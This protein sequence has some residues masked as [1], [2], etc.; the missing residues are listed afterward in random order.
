MISLLISPRI[1]RS[2]TICRRNV[3]VC[4]WQYFWCPCVYLLRRILDQLR[5]YLYP[6]LRCCRRVYGSYGIS[7]CARP[8][9]R[10]YTP[11]SSWLIIGWG[12][13][14]SFLLVGTLRSSVAFFGLFFTLTLA[15]FSLAIGHYLG[16]DEDWLKAGG[17]FGLMTASLA[18]YNA[19]SGL[20]NK[21]NSFITVPL[22]QFPWAEK[23]QPHVGR[24]P[25][26]A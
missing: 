10:L 6:V 11:S 25:R 17:W 1:W 22:G 19:L 23:G 16:G 12:V 26:R 24:R 4:H 13:F 18:W 7:R 8:L 9:S 2:R 3:G 21:G 20:W 15:F 5:L 14:T